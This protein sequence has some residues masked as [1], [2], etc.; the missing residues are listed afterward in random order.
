[1]RTEVATDSSTNRVL[2]TFQGS[3][4]TDAITSPPESRFRKSSSGAGLIAGSRSPSHS[5]RPS[6][7]NAGSAVGRS[8]RHSS[9]LHDDEI[10]DVMSRR[11]GMTPAI[12]ATDGEFRIGCA[13]PPTRSS[14]VRRCVRRWSRTAATSLDPDDGDAC[15]TWSSHV[16][17]GWAGQLPENYEEQPRR[18]LVVEARDRGQPKIDLYNLVQNQ[19][20]I[21]ARVPR[22]EP[23]SAAP[24]H[25]GWSLGMSSS[26]TAPLW[27]CAII[28]S[29][30][31]TTPAIAHR[32][33]R[34]QGR[35]D[36]NVSK[37]DWQRRQA[38]LRQADGSHPISPTTRRSICIRVQTLDTARPAPKLT[39][40][41]IPRWAV[42]PTTALWK[43]MRRTAHSVDRIRYRIVA[44]HQSPQI[45][46][47]HTVNAS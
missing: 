28:G 47:P 6:A 42:G 26:A 20:A 3:V 29:Y 7:D 16:R 11:I 12:W 39:S 9:E 32:S 23:G 10:R 24:E 4:E 33:A 8:S 41:T 17:E 14:T 37:E 2:M 36:A 18:H 43:K 25:P 44:P 38:P 1:M 40:M 15:I 35:A 45:R 34:A 30:G 19:V 31:C 13:R 46:R 22:A 5:I 27:A 21:P